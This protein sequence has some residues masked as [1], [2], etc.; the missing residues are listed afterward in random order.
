MA[1]LKQKLS[2]RAIEKPRRVLRLWDL[3]VNDELSREAMSLLSSEIL[4]QSG[5]TR[6]L[7]L[8]SPSLCPLSASVPSFSHTCP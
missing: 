6:Y 4:R 5:L 7:P 1:R 2:A 8:A 3:L